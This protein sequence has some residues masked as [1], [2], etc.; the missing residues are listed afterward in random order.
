MVLKDFYTVSGSEENENI[1][2][3]SLKVNGAHEIYKGHFPNRPVTPEV[4]LMQLFKDE[5]E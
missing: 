5:A 1:Y 4:V 3:T 2:T